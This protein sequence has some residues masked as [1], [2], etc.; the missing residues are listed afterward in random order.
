MPVCN[1]CK[2]QLPE[3]AAFCPWCGK[4][5]GPAPA[6]KTL[7]RANGMGTV[8]KLQER[9]KKP[10]AACRD[11][12]LIGCYATK[13]EALEAL[14]RTQGQE[15]N[16]RYNAT[17]DEVF[18]LWKAE[19][20]RDLSPKGVEQ[21]ELAYKHCRE[22]GPL[23]FRSIKLD[24]YQAI[25]DAMAAK[26]L[27]HSSCNKVK[28]LLG[29]MCKWAIRE[30]IIHKNQAQFIRLPEEEKKEKEIFTDAEIRKLWSAS[31]DPA[32]Q[33][34]LIMIYTGLRIG[35]LFS[36]QRDNV[37]VLE[38]Y[39]VGGLKTKAGRNRVIP[40]KPTISPFI[41]HMYDHAPAGGLLIEGYPGQKVAAN[42]RDREYYPALKRLGIQRKTPH[43]CRHT[44]TSMMVKAGVRPETLQKL[45]GHADYSTTAN[46]YVHQNVDDLRQ[47]VSMI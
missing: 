8:Y 9:R 13:T 44:F 17:F 7:K 3:G 24:R 35:E 12:V 25:I 43:S 31:A 21:Y 40:I 45:L 36:M 5:Q 41:E 34:I 30:D 38:G 19:H 2:K 42:Y 37:H 11:R 20:Y 39:M 23:K 18:T 6:R 22:L 26:G 16:E 15:I 4:R 47:A 32:V 33:I 14:E 28:Q 29:Q 46:V 1:K 10:W 27:S